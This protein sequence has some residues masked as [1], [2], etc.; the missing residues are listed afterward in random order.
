MPTAVSRQIGVSDS[1]LQSQPDH[2]PDILEII[3]NSC[4]LDGHLCTR[5]HSELG[6]CHDPKAVSMSAPPGKSQLRQPRRL[7]R[8]YPCNI[9]PAGEKF[10]KTTN[11]LDRHMKGVHSVVLPGVRVYKCCFP[12]CNVPEKIWARLDN[13]KQHVLRMHGEEHVEAAERMGVDYNPALHGPVNVSRSKSKPSGSVAD[14]LPAPTVV[15]S[16]YHSAQ[17]SRILTQKTG[18]KGT[19]EQEQDSGPS[20]GWDTRTEYSVGASLETTRRDDF[21]H[22][23][24]EKLLERVGI[25]EVD[26][27]TAARLCHGL[28]DLV[29]DFALRL[30]QDQAT[31]ELRRASVFIH[32]YRT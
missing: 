25:Q 3:T 12:D 28:Q 29:A 32:K 20:T 16:G 14:Q 19:T 22:K 21:V 8:K 30:S 24:A 23:F 5:S 1:D 26:P 7:P 2:N 13:F 17:T 15:D 27:D 18:S 9:C 10:F 31:I 11:D 6:S 4:K